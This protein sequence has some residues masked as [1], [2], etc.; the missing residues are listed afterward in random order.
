M[1][2]TAASA[3][4]LLAITLARRFLAAWFGDTFT[5]GV[6][7][8][9]LPSLA[10]FCSAGVVRL[11]FELGELRLSGQVRN[12]RGREP[13]VTLVTKWLVRSN[14]IARVT[15]LN[16]RMAE[17][18]VIS[19]AQFESP[20]L[21]ATKYTALLLIASLLT[22]PALVALYTLVGFPLC[23][24]VLGAPAAAHLL[25]RLAYMDR[26]K[27][28]SKGI[29]DEFP[30]FVIVASVLSEAG[31]SMVYALRRVSH[32]PLFRFISNEAKIVVRDIQFF[33]RSPLSAMDTRAVSTPNERL[34]WLLSGYT[35]L[36]RSGAEL[37]VFL[38]EQSREAL[39]FVA[40]R[41]KLFSERVSTLGET[42]IIAFFVVPT[43]LIVLSAF[44][45][46]QILV[47]LFVLPPVFGVLLYLLASSTRPK[48]PDFIRVNHI[49]PFIAG[50]GG[51]ASAVILRLPL[52]LIAATAL[53]LLSG[54]YY[55]EA[56]PKLHEIAHVEESLPRFLR[57]LTEYRKMGY[58][59]M[60]ALKRIAS[61][62]ETPGYS[63]EFIQALRH[64]LKQL[65]FGSDTGRRQT[66]SWLGRFT[67][68]MVEVILR[69]GEVSPAL[70]ERLTE[71]T[72]R[73]LEARDHARAQLGVYRMLGY[74][75][76]VMLA[77]VV[78]LTTSL[79]SGFGP[80]TPNLAEGT[81]L[82]AFGFTP[83]ETSL[84]DCS[85]VLSSFVIALVTEKA[86]RGT[87]LSMKPA[88]F[89]MCLSAASVEAFS[90]LA[91]YTG[92]MFSVP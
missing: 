41:W 30:F 35:A 73:L 9:L 33:G 46:A 5:E 60:K 11:Y 10:L 75:T 23:I 57:D 64:F 66:G 81:G 44:G 37:P 77:L 8:G 31:L 92:K 68:F 45:G 86:L 2:F 16:R 14:R 19:C 79:V 20:T 39:S 7:L 72:Y 15:A 49:P 53:G 52:F 61:V 76:P 25:P 47:F 13:L 36:A 18:S 82:P 43:M 91:P 38:Y 54:I 1:A 26:R 62:K 27:E 70:L 63:K 40:F 83:L 50:V 56:A 4:L 22:A 80:A 28:V 69:A 74:V 55:L 85:V 88:L 84:M 6:E 3:I 12:A 51:V 42:A 29:D 58:D 87:V 90:L 67:F 71:F 21:V 17:E 59:M 48:Q 34:S 24:T 78:N 89:S 65:E 32:S